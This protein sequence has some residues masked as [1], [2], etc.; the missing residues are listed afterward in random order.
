MF[1][2]FAGS[3]NK[4]IITGSIM[5]SLLVVSTFVAILYIRN[6]YK[7]WKESQAIIEKFLKDYRALKPTRYTYAKIKRITKQFEVKLG[8]G[9][10][11]TVFKGNISSKF[12]VAVKILNN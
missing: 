5:G 9:S 7:S 6:S 3:S 12:Q 1:I 4:Y 8:E 10:F 2:S 11:G